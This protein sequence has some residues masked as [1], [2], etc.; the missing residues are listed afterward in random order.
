VVSPIVDVT[1]LAAHLA[2]ANVRVVD[3]RWYLSVKRGADAYA[4]GHIP[5]A[6]FADLDHDLADASA[7]GPGRHPLP[8]PDAFAA[9]RARLGIKPET[10]VVGYDDAGGSIAARLWWLLRWA[11]H[12][13]G[14]VL[15][16]GV[17]AWVASGHPLSTDVPTLDHET[18]PHAGAVDAVA[19]MS[20]RAGAVAT[21]DK[22][23]VDE[24]R[25]DPKSV[26][27]DA[28]ATE[29]YEGKLEPIDARPGHVPGARSAPFAKNLG[30]D[31]KWLAASEL[32]DRYRATGALDAERVVVYC[33]SG[34]TACHDLIALAILGRDDAILYPGSW[35]DWARDASL[36]AAL[37]PEPNSRDTGGDKR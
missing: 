3:C 5:G 35:S 14:R 15:D 24:L 11:G 1:W 8:A 4:A 25:R 7:S 34:V 29:R 17:Q 36:P 28:R 16:G 30:A 31:G 21:A 22:A 10:I 37:G 23:R 27:L 32:A 13:G 20:A 26:V 6:V 18:G 33:G 9:T 19:P 12:D 2:D